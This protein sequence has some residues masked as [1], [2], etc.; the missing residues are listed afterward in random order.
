MNIYTPEFLRIKAIDKCLR[1]KTKNYFIEDLIVAANIEVQKHYP[2]HKIFQLRTIRKDIRNLREQEKL[3]NNIVS[4]LKDDNNSRDEDFLHPNDFYEKKEKARRKEAYY[5]RDISINLTSDNLNDVELTQIK[6]ALSVMTR[7]KGRPEYRRL[8]EIIL[9]LKSDLLND[10][11]LPAIM[12]YDENEQ[13]VGLEHLNTIIDG[14]KEKEALEILYQPY[15]EE[16]P[17][18][19][20]VYPYYLK[21]YN[22][23]WFLFASR[24]DRPDVNY[25]PIFPIDRIKKA[26]PCHPDKEFYKESS[27]NIE[28]YLKHVIGVSRPS[29][30]STPESV[31][32]KFHPSRYNY[33]KTK[34]LH[35]TQTFT[36]ATCTVQIRVILNWELRQLILSFG[37][38]VKVIKPDDLHR[39]M[40]M[41]S[42]GMTINYRSEQKEIT[43]NNHTL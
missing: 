38:D 1:D 3:S 27:V 14:I 36:D 39:R 9:K 31:F 25:M 22:K 42:E 28:E 10:E 5:Y 41:I 37:A 19:I 21:Q 43:G 30:D 24:K 33:I 7:I 15:T 6:D 40:K 8:N 26:I 18:I 34:P 11:E 32:L 2:G 23:R 29:F 16:K 17:E 35:F 20:I 13:L 12:G 4:E